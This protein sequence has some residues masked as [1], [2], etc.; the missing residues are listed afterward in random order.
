MK[1]NQCKTDSEV[2]QYFTS[3]DMKLWKNKYKFVYGE[4]DTIWNYFRERQKLLNKCG[5]RLSN[6]KKSI[7]NK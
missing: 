2:N 5:D 7:N 6:I 1:I 3:E 4:M